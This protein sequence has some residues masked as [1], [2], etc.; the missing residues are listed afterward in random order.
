M[1]ELLKKLNNFRLSSLIMAIVGVFGSL[2]GVGLL[3]AFSFS[4][5]AREA[6]MRKSS[7]TTI[8]FWDNR[9]AGM[10]FFIAALVAIILGIV[11]AYLA[12]AY[13]LPKQKLEPKRSFGWI[14]LAE[15]VVLVIDLVLIFVLLNTEETVIPAVWAIL[16]ALIVLSFGFSALWVYPNLKCRYYTPEIA[17]KK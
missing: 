5:V 11:V 12:M 15:N 13:I 3:F 10:V 1:K 8:A 2:I 16:A 9:V 4:H 14:L 17:K 6:G 7:M